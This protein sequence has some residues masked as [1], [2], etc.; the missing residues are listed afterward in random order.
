MCND[1][2]T[3]GVYSRWFGGNKKTPQVGDW[4]GMKPADTTAM[5]I[6]NRVC[7]TLEWKYIRFRV[8]APDK[9]M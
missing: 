1:E 6:K 3:N 8:S 5:L 9:V 7:R 2:D 4:V